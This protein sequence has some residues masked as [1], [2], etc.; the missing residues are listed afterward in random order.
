[1]ISYSTSMSGLAAMKASMAVSFWV[2][3]GRVGVGPELD[4]RLVL[5]LRRGAPDT[6]GG[7]AD[8]EGGRGRPLDECPAGDAGLRGA[9]W[10]GRRDGF[11]VRHRIF[12]HSQR[13]ARYSRTHGKAPCPVRH[14]KILTRQRDRITGAGGCRRP[15]ACSLLHCHRWL[16]VARD[17]GGDGVP[18]KARLTT[19]HRWIWATAPP[20][21]R[22]GFRGCDNIA[23]MHTHLT[24]L[25]GANRNS[26]TP[27]NIRRLG[28]GG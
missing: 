17:A 9:N 4:D 28:R 13:G 5:P 16:V 7:R 14:R 1:M 3:H 19:R 15:L 23:G 22:A 20:Y 25:T 11:L 6:A 21:R 2:D 8:P 12:S 26:G 18:E 24:S 27:Q 10:L